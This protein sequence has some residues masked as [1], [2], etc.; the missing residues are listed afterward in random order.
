M[1]ELDSYYELLGISPHER[2]ISKY[3]LLE[4]ED[5]EEDVETIES[6]VMLQTKHLRTMQAGQHAKLVAKLLN[7]V[8][9]ARILL[10]DPVKKSAYDEQLRTQQSP[11]QPRL[12]AVPRYE[13]PEP[14][15]NTSPSQPVPDKSKLFEFPLPSPQLPP[16]TFT[17]FPLTEPPPVKTFID[18]RW[19]LIGLAAAGMLILSVL[20]FVMIPSQSSAPQKMPLASALPSAGSLPVANG[21]VTESESSQTPEPTAA[22]GPSAVAEPETVP[23]S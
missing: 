23:V 19:T 10:L 9:A 12:V 14:Q 2:P 13:S 20:L 15:S 7:E 22:S 1:S 11:P 21:P 8:S 4:L 17:T 18:K 5:F 6:A 16:A 3:R